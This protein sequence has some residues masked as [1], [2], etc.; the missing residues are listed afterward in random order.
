MSQC[1][2]P[3]HVTHTKRCHRCNGRGWLA[4]KGSD[5]DSFDC[6]GCDG[7]K[8]VEC[9]EDECSAG[10]ADIECSCE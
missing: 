3:H 4:I 7:E 1:Q 9:D 10:C 5:G 6:P 2:K 8:I